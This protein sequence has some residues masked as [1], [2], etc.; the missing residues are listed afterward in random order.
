MGADNRREHDHIG[1]FNFL[2]EIQGLTAGRFKGVDG[3][4][5]ETEVIEYQ[6]GDDLL[7]RKRPGRTK[8]SNLVLKR[9]YADKSMQELWNWR[10]SVMDGKVERKTGSVILQND[11]GKEIC[12]YNF[13]E[14]WPCKWKG[15]DLDGKGTDNVVEEIELAVETIDRVSGGDQG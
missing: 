3:L 11:H 9:G 6:D 7:L 13:A 5:S 2:I 4:D 10:K 12:R 8:Y 15:W 14:A 1:Q